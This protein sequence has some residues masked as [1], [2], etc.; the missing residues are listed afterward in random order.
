VRTAGVLDLVCERRDERSVLAR[1]RFEGLA[2]SSRLP[3]PGGHARVMLSTLGPGLL[4]GDRFVTRVRVE[5]GGSLVATAQMA[6][7][8]FPGAAAAAEGTWDV[9]DAATLCV[10]GQPI[11]PL[12]GSA[13]E[14]RSTIGVAG[15]GFAV[16]AET[17]VPARGAVLRGRTLAT[18]DGTVVVRDVVELRDAVAAGSVGT[19]YA[20][21]A[22]GRLRERC[23]TA[24]W[25]ALADCAGV[26]GGAGVTAGAVVVRLC[27]GTFAVARATV[28]VADA[29]LAQRD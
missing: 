4:G 6:T 20:I 13:A 12:P 16:V 14:I 3:A 19:V 1:V 15:T 28:A 11:V 29:L 2:R 9:A 5:P 26:R 7:P 21:A 10:L 27:G 17:L 8:V 23:A 22:D 18:I 25:A 24:A